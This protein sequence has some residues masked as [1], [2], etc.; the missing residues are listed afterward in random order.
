[1]KISKN[2]LPHFGFIKISKNI[3]PPFPV[4]SITS[5]TYIFSFSFNVNVNIIGV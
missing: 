4:D 1:M 5:I 3:L 2:I